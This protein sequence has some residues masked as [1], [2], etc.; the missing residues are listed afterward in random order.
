MMP[1]SMLSPNVLHEL[2]ESARAAPPGPLVEVGV[3][4]G[5]SA[6]ALAQVAREQKRELYLFDTFTGIPYQDAKRDFHKVGDFADTSLE[7]VRRAIP[8]AICIAGVFPE[9]LP[10]HVVGVA[11]AH[12]D[13]DQYESIVSACAA[14]EPRMVRGGMMV[15]DDYDVLP[16][17]REAV[18]ELYGDCVEISVQG[19]ARVR[20]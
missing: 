8:E 3:Y 17:A 20:F 15:F 12:I 4:K 14:L 13:C 6:A 2:M 16:G 10:G 9:T 18:D 19:K 5:G 11:L 1:H 7:E